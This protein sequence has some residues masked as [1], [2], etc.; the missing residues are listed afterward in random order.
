MLGNRG[1]RRDLVAPDEA[2]KDV[3]RLTSVLL[4]SG[5]NFASTVEVFLPPSTSHTLIISCKLAAESTVTSRCYS[6]I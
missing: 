1:M 6:D 2:V 5:D 4:E 3:Q